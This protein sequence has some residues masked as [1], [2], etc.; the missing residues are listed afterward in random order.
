LA[1]NFTRGVCRWPVGIASAKEDYCYR[2]QHPNAANV[3]AFVQKCL[4]TEQSVASWR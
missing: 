1:T 4:T 2:Y 3:A